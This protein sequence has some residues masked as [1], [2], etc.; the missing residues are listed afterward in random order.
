MKAIIRVLS[1]VTVIVASTSGVSFAD[2]P[3]P[4]VY[5]PDALVYDWS[6][7]YIGGHVGAAFNNGTIKLNTGTAEELKP[8]GTGFIGG[9]QL[10][11]QKQFRD[12]VIGAEISYSWLGPG[13]TSASTVQ[14]GLSLTSDVSNLLLATGK[15]GLADMN[16]LAYMK[17]GYALANV[18]Y[19]TGGLFTSS[20][21]GRGNGFLGGL[22]MD[23]A[24]KPH[25]ILG[26][27]YNFIKLFTDE[28]TQ[29]LSPFTTIVSPSNFDIQ[30]VTLRLDFKFG[31]PHY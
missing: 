25:M 30:T 14:P 20:T 7:F 9:G 3:D 18:D 2:G 16:Y 6:G 27:E 10:G 4:Y 24:L 29:A 15:I 23:Y 12:T 28:R 1:V 19:K 13:L 17:A 8:G 31:G 22:G 11:V 5:S 26:I 21:S